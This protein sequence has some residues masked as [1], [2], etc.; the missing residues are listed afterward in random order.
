MCKVIFFFVLVCLKRLLDV[1]GKKGTAMIILDDYRNYNETW[2]GNAD[3]DSVALYN[4][5]DD[6]EEGLNLAKND[7]MLEKA[8][9][10]DVHDVKIMKIILMI[11]LK[12]DELR[13]RLLHAGWTITLILMTMMIMI[14]MIVMNDN[15]DNDDNDDVKG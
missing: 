5:K 9:P 8:R 14:I 10:S 11:M 4:L 1:R 7:T 15:Y 13:S 12:V 3:V 6:P 2:N